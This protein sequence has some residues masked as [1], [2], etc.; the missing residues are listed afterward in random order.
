MKSEV[1]NKALYTNSIA[2]CIVPSWGESNPFSIR[3]CHT[4]GRVTAWLI[5]QQQWR[6]HQHI[7]H[8]HVLCVLTF[9]LILVSN[10]IHLTFTCKP[11]PFC[12]DTPFCCE[13]PQLLTISSSLLSLSCAPLN[14]KSYTTIK[15]ERETTGATC[16]GLGRHFGCFEARENRVLI[17]GLRPPSLFT[18]YLPHHQKSI[19]CSR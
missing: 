12:R 2:L 6:Q 16:L 10:T 3:T 4:T 8:K 13:G 9:I 7:P 15:R 1:W 17:S 11:T 14:L 5:Q 19:P 18:P